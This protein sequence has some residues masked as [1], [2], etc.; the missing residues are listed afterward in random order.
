MPEE[1]TMVEVTLALVALAGQ[2]PRSP[3]D[4]QSP[5]APARTLESGLEELA[6]CPIRG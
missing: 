6:S 3:L 5:R 4:W 2:V 1:C